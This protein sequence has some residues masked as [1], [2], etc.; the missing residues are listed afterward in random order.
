M[1]PSLLA[2][3]F[4][5]LPASAELPLAG[6]PRE[7]NAAEDSIGK[8]VGGAGGRLAASTGEDV[9][10]WA[11][12]L[13]KVEKVVSGKGAGDVALTE[14]FRFMAGTRILKSKKR[15][16]KI[17]DG[18]VIVY[19]V[20]KGKKLEQVTGPMASAFSADGSKLV[21]WT[22]GP[23]TS[24]DVWVRDMASGKTRKVW[25][26]PGICEETGSAFQPWSCEGV[27]A[28]APSPDGSKI[29]IARRY[30]K[31]RYTTEVKGILI[32]DADSGEVVRKFSDCSEDKKFLGAGNAAWSRDG[33]FIAYGG[34]TGYVDGDCGLFVREA[35]SGLL[36][37]SSTQAVKGLGFTADGAH[38]LSYSQDGWKRGPLAAWESKTGKL[39][40]VPGVDQ[41]GEF[42]VSP[43]GSYLFVQKIGEPKIKAFPLTPSAA[44]AAPAPEAKPE[45]AA[46][47][48][49]PPAAKTSI[50]PD[51]LAVVVGVERY[52]QEGIPAVS[53]AASDARIV[54][55]Y[56]TKSMGF[57]P[58]NVILLA[59]EQATK[60][61]LEKY[62][63]PWLENR[64]SEKSRVFVYFAGH[65]SPDP[66]T[67][68]AYL[69]PYEGDPTYTKVSGYPLKSLYKTLAALPAKSVTVALDSCFSG[70][71]QRSVIA[72]GARPLVNV[73]TGAPEGST[74][75]LAAAAGDQISGAYPEGRHGLMTYF[76]L[77]GLSGAADDDKDGAVTT[78]ELYAYVR[79]N[80]EREAR[81]GNREQ[82]PLLQGLAD[83]S[84]G[85]VLI[86]LK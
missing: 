23:F 46:S 74:V 54:H 7:L 42:A 17:L 37:W 47:V 9:T 29:L 48:D 81:R 59:N 6:E 56:L 25:S 78:R 33:R 65:G 84:A 28:A 45:A 12:G 66:K 80:V 76:L 10:L 27:M 53:Y 77:R 85:P 58:K 24:D 5:A 11:P 20:E 50:D 64:A 4:A 34:M 73:K 68:E 32:L 86:R 2:L 83:Q 82:T 36:L 40:F 75:V 60:T 67:G 16:A 43:D 70:A 71:G 49:A 51:A 13:D 22:G 57:D 38:L 62:L 31:D 69:M 35:E 14:D 44:V 55:A 8:L 3:V 41:V 26:G 39:S 30:W 63:G 52:R 19:D 21:M 15:L 79:P 1:I 72:A 61:D 18:S